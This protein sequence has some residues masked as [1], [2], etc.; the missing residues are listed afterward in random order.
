MSA[1]LFL[2]ALP[3][4]PR[5][6]ELWERWMRCEMHGDVDLNNPQDAA[7]VASGKLLSWDEYYALTGELFGWLGDS[8]P[9]RCWI[10]QVSWLKA[11]LLDDT[12]TWVPGPVAA[13]HTIVMADVPPI[14]DGTLMA[15]VMVAMNAPNESWFARRVDY[16]HRRAEQRSRFQ[17][18]S[19]PLEAGDHAEW[20]QIQGPEHPIG[21]RRV[22]LS[23]D[24][25]REIVAYRRRGMNTRRVVKRWLLANAGARIVGVSE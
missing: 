9:P 5:T 8:T 13:V 22:W 2:Y 23:P 4:A 1:D 3:N 20:A 7:A 17:R 10:G 16:I 6:L 14:I 18:R 25:T 19:A 15:R 11:A 12:E 24:R 21:P